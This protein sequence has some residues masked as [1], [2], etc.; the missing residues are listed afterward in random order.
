M[1]EGFTLSSYLR[2]VDWTSRLHR[3][4]KAHVP[5]EIVSLLNR[6]GT[7]ADVWR[8]TMERLHGRDRE[9]GVF[10]TFDRSRLRELAARRHCSRVANI[11]GCPA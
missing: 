4:R 2:L 8:R 10:F 11:N 5:E 6:L 9:L 1:L 3:T 7:S